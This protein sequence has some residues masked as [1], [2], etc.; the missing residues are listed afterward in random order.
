MFPTI[1]IHYQ[2]NDSP[3]SAVRCLGVA[4]QKSLIHWA[5]SQTPESVS[6]GSHFRVPSWCPCHIAPRPRNDY[7]SNTVLRRSFNS[8]I[9]LSTLKE[10]VWGVLILRSLRLTTA[11]AYSV[12]RSIQAPLGKPKSWIG[13]IV[14]GTQWS[15]L[16]P[17][18]KLPSFFSRVSAE[19]AWSSSESCLVDR[20]D[21]ETQDSEQLS[22]VDQHPSLDNINISNLTDSETPNIARRYLSATQVPQLN[23]G[24]SH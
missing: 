14:D 13:S 2:I 24:T 20:T 7:A 19:L 10:T 22:T 8:A 4:F 1:T 12:L 21:Q 3:H 23:A 5:A 6:H 17:S 15:S 16:P 11:T 18:A 9:L